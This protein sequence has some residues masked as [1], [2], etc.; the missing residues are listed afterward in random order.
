MA[1]TCKEAKRRS[2]DVFSFSRRV[3][4]RFLT[5]FSDPKWIACALAMSVAGQALLGEKKNR[6]RRPDRRLLAPL[7]VCE[8]SPPLWDSDAVDFDDVCE[9]L[10]MGSS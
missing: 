6:S 4:N 1:T 9:E 10:L 7:P 5:P 8:P 2:V 3:N